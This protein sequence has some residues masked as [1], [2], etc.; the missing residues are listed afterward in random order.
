VVVTSESQEPSASVLALCTSIGAT[1]AGHAKPLEGVVTAGLHV[2]ADGKLWNVIQSYD[3]SVWPDPSAPSLLALV[4][5]VRDPYVASNWVQPIDQ[6]DA[7]KLENP[8]TGLPDE[9]LH[10]GKR[11]KVA[12]GDGAGNNIWQP[13]VFGWSEVL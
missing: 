9:C 6:F 1:W 7:Y 3:T 8:F 5:E 2:D 11:W 12:Q 4:R 13:G 10:N